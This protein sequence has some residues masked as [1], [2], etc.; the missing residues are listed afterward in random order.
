MW[1][2][3]VLSKDMILKR[4]YPTWF[5]SANTVFTNMKARLMHRKF[6][7]GLVRANSGKIKRHFCTEI[8]RSTLK[9]VN[10][11]SLESRTSKDL[12]K[13][14]YWALWYPLLFRSNLM[15]FSVL[16]FLPSFSI[17]VSIT[18]QSRPKFLFSA[19]W[20]SFLDWFLFT[21]SFTIDLLKH[22]TLHPNLCQ[23][24][25]PIS[26][27]VEKFSPSRHNKPSSPSNN[28]IHK[29]PKNKQRCIDNKPNI[30]RLRLKHV[31][32]MLSN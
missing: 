19:F 15:R 22:L 13:N 26:L 25:L 30:S 9:L 3:V 6:L 18:I 10:R 8:L 12:V 7:S 11:N 24:S 29:Q 32:L 5:S 2:Y 27:K 4:D 28:R 1:I 21:S 16:R 23:Q 20:F 17:S 31:K 14:L